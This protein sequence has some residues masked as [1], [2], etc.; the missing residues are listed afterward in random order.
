VDRGPVSPQ[1]ST[2]QKYSGKGRVKL[3]LAE[4]GDEASGGNRSDA[5]EVVIAY[6]K[7]AGAKEW[8]KACGYLAAEAKAQAAELAKQSAPDERS[9]GENLSRLVKAFEQGAESPLYAPSGILSLRIEEGGL[10]G[11]GTGFA[12]FHAS[13]GKD[14]WLAMRREGGKWKTLSTTP[15]P[16]VQK[17]RP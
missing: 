2:F 9:C 8:V 13:D 5:S 11:E 4:F 16:F 7:A 17:T 12:L 10:N 1:S 14:W 6:L 15:Q 3:H